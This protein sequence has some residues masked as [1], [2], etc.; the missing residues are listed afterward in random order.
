MVREVSQDKLYDT[1]EFNEFLTMIA[2]QKKHEITHEDLVEAFKYVIW[3]E[4]HQWYFGYFKN[5]WQE[6]D[7]KYIEGRFL[8]NHEQIWSWI[9]KVG[10]FKIRNNIE[11]FISVRS[12][13]LWWRRQMWDKTAILIT[14]V[15]API[16][17]LMTSIFRLSILGFSKYLIGKEKSMKKRSTQQNWDNNRII[18]S[19][20]SNSAT[21]I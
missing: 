10:S 18:P 9:D 13:W 16:Y 7:W 14:N 4:Y 6:G 15:C 1:V 11:Y 12:W 2:M 19:L 8:Q 21:D 5:F 17:N 20:S 3:G